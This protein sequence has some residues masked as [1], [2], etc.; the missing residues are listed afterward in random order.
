M[1]ACRREEVG[2]VAAGLEYVG[3]EGEDVVGDKGGEEM[4]L[5]VA[6][7]SCWRHDGVLLELLAVAVFVSTYFVP[8]FFWLC[9]S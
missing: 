1:Q 6:L 2:R 5:E 8:S 7:F 3:A 4:G 9:R